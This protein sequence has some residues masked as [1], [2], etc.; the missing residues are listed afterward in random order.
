[1]AKSEMTQILDKYGV[2]VTEEKT[3]DFLRNESFNILPSNEVNDKFGC[4]FKVA[5][6]QFIQLFQ[7]DE[8]D[9]YEHDLQPGK[10]D[11][12]KMQRW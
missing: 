4:E 1:M 8:N 11:I 10:K 5:P 6:G 12:R 2:N 9:G 7:Y 3:L